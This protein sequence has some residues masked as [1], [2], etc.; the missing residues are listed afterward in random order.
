VV[1]GFGP[2]STLRPGDHIYLWEGKFQSNES[3]TNASS[4][5]LITVQAPERSRVPVTVVPV[6]P[7]L[8]GDCDNITLD[9]SNSVGSGGRPWTAVEFSVA[10]SAAEGSRLALEAFLNTRYRL[11]PPTPISTDMLPRNHMYTISIRTCNFLGSCGVGSVSF[12]KFSDT[13]P[14][15]VIGGGVARLPRPNS[16]ALTASATVQSCDGAVSNSGFRYLWSVEEVL[17]DGTRINRPDIVSTSLDQ[18]VFTLP[19]YRLSPLSSYIFTV[20][21]TYRTVMN[22]VTVHVPNGALVALIKGAT[23]RSI[24]YGSNVLLDA[25][26]SYDE[27]RGASLALVNV[28]VRWSCVRLQPTY[29]EDC[30][31]AMFPGANDL[32]VSVSASIADVN[33]TFRVSIT[34]R[35]MQSSRQSRASMVLDVLSKYQT[36]LVAATSFDYVNVVQKV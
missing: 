30:G 8:I 28:S 5:Q 34:V 12:E 17:S 26:N 25:S 11:V 9:L 29:S 14:N 19:P 18:S 3:T 35:D 1:I 33:S 36:S 15:L 7:S 4:M 20:S 22:S 21:N 2:K 32:I 13:V 31:L 10:S 6:A 16:L 27:N 24:S 23:R